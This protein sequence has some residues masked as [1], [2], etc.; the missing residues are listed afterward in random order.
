MLVNTL[1]LS[2]SPRE[3][4]RQQQKKKKKKGEEVGGWGSESVC[5]S[6]KGSAALKSCKTSFQT[7]LIYRLRERRQKTRIP[8]PLGW[9]LGRGEGGGGE[10]GTF[11]RELSRFIKK[12]SG[13]GCNYADPCAPVCVRR[14]DFGSEMS[15]AEET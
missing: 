12:G 6:D 9:G 5:G 13:W 8:F 3:E 2:N 7:G 14:A 15:S 4:K 11:I 1:P 10:E